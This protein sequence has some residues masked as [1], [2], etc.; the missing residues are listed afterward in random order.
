M[1]SFGSPYSRPD[2]SFYNSKH[3]LQPWSEQDR[4]H[5]AYLL[6]TTKKRKLSKLR[7]NVFNKNSYVKDKKRHVYVSVKQ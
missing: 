3:L 6:V 2:C 1:I 5:V 4:R 7:S